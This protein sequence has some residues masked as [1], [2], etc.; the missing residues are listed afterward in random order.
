MADYLPCSPFLRL[1]LE[2]RDQIYGYL[3]PDVDEVCTKP[4]FKENVYHEGDIE[5]FDNLFELRR[6]GDYC[7]PAILAVNKQVHAEASRIM[8]NRTY[9]IRASPKSIEF[10]GAEYPLAP[11]NHIA[12]PHI[13]LPNQLDDLPVAFPFH[14]ARAIRVQVMNSV[15]P[16]WVAWEHIGLHLKELSRVLEKIAEKDLPLNR[17]IIDLCAW[18]DGSH[19]TEIEDIMTLFSAFEPCDRIAKFCELK[20]ADWVT[21]SPEVVLM[22]RTLGRRIIYRPPLSDVGIDN[23]ATSALRTFPAASE[24]NHYNENLILLVQERL[25]ECEEEHELLCTKWHTRMRRI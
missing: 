13:R 18:G 4:G 17:L 2:L 14:K 23:T 3:M 10:L 12:G 21:T 6:D 16:G 7:Y 25:C 20:F 1:P 22:A 15:F 19:F 5:W 11:Y 9:T 8:W 24:P